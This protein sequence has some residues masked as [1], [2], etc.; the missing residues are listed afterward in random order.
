MDTL[1][2]NAGQL[3]TFI[4]PSGPRRGAEMSKTGLCR[5]G[6][7]L[8]SEGKIV[9]AGMHDLVS[10]HPLAPKARVLDLGGRVALPGFVDS[11]APLPRR[12]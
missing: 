2:V 8:I 9:T 5:D 4:G 10:R 12:G 7:V 3:L 11:H 6:A 1:L